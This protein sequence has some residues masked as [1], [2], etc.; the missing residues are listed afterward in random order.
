MA[1][2][3]SV[4]HK[5]VQADVQIQAPNA[6]RWTATCCEVAI[7][8]QE[9]EA[10]EEEEEDNITSVMAVATGPGWI[11]TTFTLLVRTACK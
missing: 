5:Q 7:M 2:V 11:K 3:F 9:A 10:E 1:V 8:Q 4:T 6:D